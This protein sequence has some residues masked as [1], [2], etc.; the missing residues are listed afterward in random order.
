MPL[1]VQKIENGTVID[2]IPAGTGNRVLHLLSS[3]YPISKMAALIMNA[4][5]K[6]YGKKDIVKIEGVFLDEKTANR[7]ALIAPNATLNIIRA[8]KL[9]DKHPVEMPQSISGI[10]ACPN[11]KC[12]SNAEHAGTVFIRAKAGLLRCRHC[13]RLF[14]PEELA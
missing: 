4:P 13:E 5:S 9:S 12:I 1:A 3:H 2:H 10:A 8:G 7:I 11:P 14:R 6:K